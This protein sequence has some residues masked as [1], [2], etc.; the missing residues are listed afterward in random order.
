MDNLF[1]FLISFFINC[2]CWITAFIFM[3][4]N[5]FLSLLNKE[6]YSTLL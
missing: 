3:I 5:S 2:K 4:E 1:L 6:P